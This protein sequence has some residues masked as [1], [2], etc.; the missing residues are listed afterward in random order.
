MTGIIFKGIENRRFS[1]LDFYLARANRIIPAL[2]A[3][4][5]AIIIM[6]W[7]IL[8]ANEYK[9]VSKH[10]ASSI[11]FISNMVYWSE[12]GYFDTSS[13]EKWLLHT[14]SLSVEWQFYI[15]YPVIILS[16]N[17]F[18]KPE[19]TKIALL[20][21]TALSLAHSVSYT[22]QNPSFSYY[23]IT[24]RAWEM[25]LGG[26]VFLFP[27][28]MS[29]TASKISNLFG[30]TLIII[31][32]FLVS[33]KNPWPGHLA[34]LPAIGTWLIIQ[35]NLE[36]NWLTDNLL[37]QKIG[38][39][40][41]SIYLWHWPIVVILNLF[42]LDGIYIYI[43]LFL[44]IFFGLI[45]NKFIENIK[46]RKNYKHGINYLYSKP[47]L[48]VL[49]TGFISTIIYVNEGIPTRE[50]K[51]QSQS[52]SSVVFSPYRKDC[53][54]DVYKDPRKA[55]EYF[56]QNITWAAFGDSHATEI[57]Y[58]L[59]KR[60]EPLNEGVKHL[61]FSGCA[62][63]Y[64]EKDKSN[65]CIRWYND[66]IKYILDNEDIKNVIYNH[67]F[68]QAI[69]GGDQNKYPRDTNKRS[70]PKQTEK[71]KRIDELVILLSKSKDNVYIYYPIPELPKDI[72]Q[73]IRRNSLISSSQTMKST[74]L[75][76]YRERNREIIQHFKESNYPKN[77]HL[78][79]TEHV[80]C[81]EANCF[82]VK[83]GVSLYFDDDH[84]SVEA[85]KRLVDLIEFKN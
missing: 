27:I 55:C 33:E 84:P 31:C 77:V 76:W 79:N 34:I 18:L 43:G 11:G 45:S 65:D 58:A 2:A 56:S 47:A 82:A 59:A 42:L 52:L 40:S 30:L 67:R 21:F 70:G 71:L 5:I 4:C 9:A 54:I 75:S 35:A 36:K 10:V 73:I 83:D 53:H 3:L 46:F 72:K 44:S 25:L 38:T 39:W 17:K 20:I 64:L 13:H 68:T 22:P 81:N 26:L 78:L 29:N 23:S 14:W 6:G 32:Y 51:N 1:L 15:I 37:F 19:K 49:F 12:A 48:A 60:I 57:A 16:L 61:T 85:A 74:S 41:Y 28:K 69:F 24:T 8:T 50:T 7:F 63:S 66:S 62:P 80:F